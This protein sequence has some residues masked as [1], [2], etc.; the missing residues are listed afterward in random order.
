MSENLF[1]K[2]IQGVKFTT[3]LQRSYTTC[4]RY[5]QLVAEQR[6]D[7]RLYITPNITIWSENSKNCEITDFCNL[8][9]FIFV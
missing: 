9:N 6:P 1:V 2:T 3:Y 4:P 7:Y 8:S 5:N